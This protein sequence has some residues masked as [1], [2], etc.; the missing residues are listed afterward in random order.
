[1]E[2][3]PGLSWSPHRVL[4]IFVRDHHVTLRSSPKT[5]LKNE[6]PWLKQPSFHS[7]QYNK[8]KDPWRGN[9][10]P[11]TMSLWTAIYLKGNVP[12]VLLNDMSMK[13][14][15][16]FN[17]YQNAHFWTSPVVQWLRTRLPMQGTQFSPWSG[18]PPRV[19]QLS[20]WATAA[21]PALESPHSTQERPPVRGTLG[22]QQ[23]PAPTR[24]NQRKQQNPEQKTNKSH[25]F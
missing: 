14:L 11:L 16:L 20:P 25:I 7:Q 4:Q 23:R 10:C 5:T 9:L 6:R 22:P 2:G 1:M 8:W 15:L 17:S 21:G 24:H 18:L 13:A 3:E 12:Y 19:E